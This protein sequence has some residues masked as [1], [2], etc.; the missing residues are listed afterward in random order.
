MNTWT[1]R[2]IVLAR[3][4]GYLDALSKIYVMNINPRRP[5]TDDVERKLRDAFHNKK[6]KELMHLLI[7]N[8]VFPVKDSYVGFFRLAPHAIDKNPKTIERIAERLYALGI[9]GLIREA[10]RPK[11]TNR[12]LGNS[13]RKWL[14]R[15]GYPVV[16]SADFDRTSGIAILRG[17]DSYLAQYARKKLGCRLSKGIDILLK[18][19]NRYLIGEAKFLTTPGGEQDR[20]FDDASNF[21]KGKSGPNVKRIAILDGYIWLERETGLHR[22]IVRNNLDIFSALLLREYIKNF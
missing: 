10:T 9:S 14:P 7:Q 21:I 6:T 19:G 12:Q 15:L 3:S 16:N 20:G 17:G 5:L 2:S 13:F 18:S 1:R 11:E 8:E 22:K 4:A